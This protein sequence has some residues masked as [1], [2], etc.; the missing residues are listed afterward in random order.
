MDPEVYDWANDRVPANGGTVTQKQAEAVNAWMLKVK[1]SSGLREKLKRVNL[2]A[3]SNLSAKMVPLIIDSGYSKVDKNTNLSEADSVSTGLKAGSGKSIDTTVKISDFA[4]AGSGHISVKNY[5]DLSTLVTGDTFAHGVI[6]AGVKSNLGFSIDSEGVKGY[7]WDNANAASYAKTNQAALATKKT[8]QTSDYTFGSYKLGYWGPAGSKADPAWGPWPSWLNSWN[9]SDQ[10]DLSYTVE[11]NGDHL[12]DIGATRVLSITFPSNRHSGWN[13]CD[14]KLSFYKNDELL[15]SEEFEGELGG[16]AWGSGEGKSF[17]I[18]DL[19]VGDKIKVLVGQGRD[20]SRIGVMY[21][22]ADT[23]V[24]FKRIVPSTQNALDGLWTAS[25]T[26]SSSL[27]LYLDGSE[28]AFLTELASSD[29]VTTDDYVNIMGSYSSDGSIQ[30]HHNNASRIGFYSLGLGLTAAENLTLSEAMT[31]FDDAMRRDLDEEVWD[32]AYSRLPLNGGSLSEAE[33]GHVNTFMLSLKTESGLRESIKRL[34]IFAGNGLSSAMVPLIKDFGD[35]IEKNYNFTSSDVSQGL[36]SNGSKYIDTG[37]SFSDLDSLSYS[38]F[39]VALSRKGNSIGG[40]YFNSDAIGDGSVKLN[41]TNQP[42]PPTQEGQDALGFSQSTITSSHS[43]SGLLVGTSCDN[44]ETKLYKGG[45]A[46]FDTEPFDGSSSISANNF[47]VFANQTESG[48]VSAFDGRVS[49]Y[50]LGSGLTSGQVSAF[51]LAISVLEIS[52]KRGDYQAD[53]PDAW[54]WANVNVPANSGLVTQDQVTAVDKFMNSVSNVHNLRSSIKRMNLFVGENLNAALVPVVSDLGTAS[55]VNNN[56]ISSDYVSTGPDAGLTGGETKT[57]NLKVKASDLGDNHLMSFRSRSGSTFA[58]SLNAPIMGA[59]LGLSTRRIGSNLGRLAFY[60]SAT[61]AQTISSSKY[62][63]TPAI[64][65][66]LPRNYLGCDISGGPLG[67]SLNK[68]VNESSCETSENAVSNYSIANH[69]SINSALS[70]KTLNDR[71]YYDYRNSD[72]QTVSES[73]QIFGE[74]AVTFTIDHETGRIA[75]PASHKQ[76][77]GT[78]SPGENGNFCKGF[79]SVLC[80]KD[81]STAGSLQNVN[82]IKIYKDGQ[83][84]LESQISNQIVAPEEEIALFGIKNGSVFHSFPTSINIDFYCLGSCP[85][86]PDSDKNPD[87]LD[88]GFLPNEINS[89]L[90]QLDVDL[91]RKGFQKPNASKGILGNLSVLTN[92]LDPEVSKWANE[93]VRKVGGELNSEIVL[94]VNAWMG[95]IKERSGLRQKIQRVNLFSSVNLAGA[96]V[97]IISDE[98]HPV[99][100]NQG[101]VQFSE[102][103]FVLGRLH[104]GV[105]WDSSSTT[106]K[107]YLDT[108]LNPTKAN[109]SWDN[110]HMG[111]ATSLEKLHGDIRQGGMGYPTPISLNCGDVNGDYLSNDEVRISTYVSCPHSDRR[112]SAP[113]SCRNWINANLA[114]GRFSNYVEL[115]S[116]HLSTHQTIYMVTSTSFTNRWTH[117][118]KTLTGGVL[119]GSKTTSW[120]SSLDK[121]FREDKNVLLFAEHANQLEASSLVDDITKYGGMIVPSRHSLTPIKFSD[122][123]YYIVA[124]TDQKFTLN[125]LV[126]P[127]SGTNDPFKEYVSDLYGHGWTPLNYTDIKNEFWDSSKPEGAYNFNRLIKDLKHGHRYDKP[128]GWVDPNN[129]QGFGLNHAI[130]STRL[131]LHNDNQSSA[132]KSLNKY[133]SFDSD[134]ASETIIR[135]I[136]SSEMD[137]ACGTCGFNLTEAPVLMKIEVPDVS[138]HTDAVHNQTWGS[139]ITYYSV[140]VELDD[141][142]VTHLDNAYASFVEVLDLKDYHKSHPTSL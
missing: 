131:L 6:S 51:S 31:A 47:V 94:A 72:S 42:L 60:T 61:S 91:N 54:K 107:K 135:A 125:N 43:G 108:G 44:T 77:A 103:D 23:Q 100:L 134:A 13:C 18:S 117:S 14:S 120:Y 12:V 27:S 136:N 73:S 58:T 113:E 26:S 45:S 139:D 82:K 10:A 79:Y 66:D 28:K 50:S 97:P 48:V 39:H 76:K 30:N 111:F 34:N 98:G 53:D 86:T 110:I 37:M 141:A 140:G 20:A 1:S 83:G 17:V 119:R 109:L 85:E 3:G 68:N 63:K 33:I 24:L 132:T 8:I 138:S 57:L 116:Y 128:I 123:K 106:P 87:V 36:T 102:E 101:T 35:S 59:E 67:S 96:L 142:D 122:G 88:D 95:K 104:A 55:E 81:V 90:I 2:M 22:L 130:H 38:N 133:N 49:V 21:P 41:L 19:A 92:E 105:S 127:S 62:I 52:L 15:F 80:S 11:E 64:F 121:K 9:D 126:R 93:K 32:W 56:F 25:R 115:P 7:V 84:V 29:I 70:Q 112:R 46:N 89:F 124:L 5:A 74:S 137:V 75:G 40:Y 71:L 16:G 118:L 114:Q 4:T 69:S 65:K 129:I 99:D 78:P